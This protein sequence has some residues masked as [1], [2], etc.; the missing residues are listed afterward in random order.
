M[1]KINPILKSF[2]AGELSPRVEGRLD[3]DNFRNGLRV[4]ENAV[5]VLQGPVTRRGAFRFVAEVKDSSKAVRLVPFEVGEDAAYALEM[6]ETYFR[7]YKDGTR[8]ESGGA[9]VEVATPYLE[10]E[11][12]GIHYAQS[13]DLLY[14]VHNLHNTRKLSRLDASGTAWGFKS[15][16]FNP[17]PTFEDDT[18]VSGGAIAISPDAVTGTGIKIRASADV[19]L[20]ADKDRLVKYL[21]GL[22]SITAVGGAREITVEFIDDFP[23]SLAP[24]AGTGT[25]ATVGADASFLLPHG[26]AVGSWV[27]L[28]NGAQVGEKKRVVAVPDPTHA[29]L[30][31]AFSVDQVGTAWSMDFEITGAQGWKLGGSPVATLTPSAAS[32]LAAIATLTLSAE[33]WRQ[34]DVTLGK[35]VRVSGGVVK[36]TTYTSPTVVSGQIMKIL[37]DINPA[38]GGAWSAEIPSWSESTGYPSAACFFE[39]RFFLGGTTRQPTSVWGSQNGDYENFAVGTNP[40]DAVVFPLTSIK[41]NK[42]RWLLPAKVLL[43]G[44]VSGEFS[45]NGGAD[46]AITP[47][48]PRAR[49][50]TTHGGSSVMPVRVGHLLLFVQAQGRKVRELSYSFQPDAFVAPDLTRFAEH[51]SEGGGI[52]DMAYQQEPESI[53]WCV[54]ADGVLLGCTYN[55]EE[56]VFGWHRHTTDGA[57]ESVCV[58][59]DPANNRDQLWAVVRREIGGITKRYIEVYEPDRAEA[60]SYVAFSGGPNTIFYGLSHL[61]GKE[62]D[63]VA[64]GF[65]V[66]GKTVTGGSVT[67]DRA[68]TE[69]VVGLHYETTVEPQRPD[70]VDDKG[71]TTIGVKKQWQEVILRLYRTGLSGVT[72]NGK[73]VPARSGSDPLDTATALFTGDALLPI[74]G[75][76]RDG[77]LTIKQT[78]PLPFTLLAITG[79]LDLGD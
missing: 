59:P 37:L 61:E 79:T 29:T 71:R 69:A 66:L 53:L 33:G 26:L 74:L 45:I 63:V 5:C 15:V 46:E 11:L 10:S 62:V 30:E 47:T 13:A 7:F 41:V 76:T 38:A 8:V 50:E 9:P 67:L 49:S 75:T 40:A 44:T 12:F 56:G 60:D 43:G 31:S 57:F 14:L 32:P 35:Y 58:I 52:V 36:L 3:L 64:D 72:V 65:V 18:D 25:I 48:N 23:A 28:T 24:Q 20:A 17:P 51:I 77:I 68:A 54:R 4:L 1:A 19:F 34:V 55:R 78:L 73:T 6:G 70:F 42:V 21:D 2:N 27:R 39:E 16:K 22:A